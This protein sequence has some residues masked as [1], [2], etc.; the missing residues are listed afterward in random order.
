L[1]ISTKLHWLKLAFADPKQ[2]RP[3]LTHQTLT[4]QATAEFARLAQRLRH[5]GHPSQTVAH[6]INRL[7]LCMFAEDFDL[8]PEDL[9][10]KQIN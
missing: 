10:K 7:V 5:R 1:P 3:G 2:L 9:H 6:F 4:E 8:L